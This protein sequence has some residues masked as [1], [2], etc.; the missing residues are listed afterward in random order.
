MLEL[1]ISG[2]E[3]NSPSGETAYALYEHYL[4]PDHRNVESALEL[5]GTELIKN[6]CS[7]FVPLLQVFSPARPDIIGMVM[8]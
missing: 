7:D 3:E 1:S 8:G 6:M 5:T 2:A 4:M